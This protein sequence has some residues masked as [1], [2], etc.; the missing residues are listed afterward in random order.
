MVCGCE[1]LPCSLLV[2][3]HA[4]IP[5]IVGG[6]VFYIIMVLKFYFLYV[7]LIYEKY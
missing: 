3:P 7:F 2:F 5:I 4:L 6:H 1:Y